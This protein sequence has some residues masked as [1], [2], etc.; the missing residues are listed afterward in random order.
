MTFFKATA[1]CGRGLNVGSKI[2]ASGLARIN[3]C[4]KIKRDWRVQKIGDSVVIMTNKVLE[5]F[6]DMNVVV[7]MAE[8]FSWRCLWS[9][10]KKKKERKKS[11]NIDSNN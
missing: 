3:Q 11:Q 8:Y 9:K 1:K 10:K 6:Y 5:L 2:N 7:P 4:E